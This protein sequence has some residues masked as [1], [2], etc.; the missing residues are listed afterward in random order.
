MPLNKQADAW[1]RFLRQYGPVPQNNNMYDEQIER[2]ARRKNVRPILFDHPFADALLGHFDGSRE[3][4]GAVILTGTAGDGKTFLLKKVWERL[5][6]S[7]NEWAESRSYFRLDATVGGEARRF[8]LVRDLTG[9]SD[10]VDGAAGFDKRALLRRTS[11]AAVGRG[12]IGDVFLLAANDGQLLEECRAL[13]ETEDGTNLYAL[14]ERLL[15][16]PL[17]G[18]APERLVFFNLARGRSTE[19]LDRALDALLGHEGWES[20]RASDVSEDEAFGVRCPIRR[21]LELL[22]NEIVRKRLRALVELCDANDLHLSIREIL[23]VLVNALLGHPAAK[24]QVL[25]PADV[26]LVVAQGAVGRA[27]LYN[28]VFGGNL[29]EHRRETYP[30]FGSLD[31]FRVGYETSN[32][33]DGL[34]VFGPSDPNLSGLYDHLMRSDPIFGE[35]PEFAAAQREYIEGAEETEARGARFLELLVEK[36]RLLFFSLPEPG[37]SDPRLVEQVEEQGLRLWD[38][39]VFKFAGD[40]LDRVVRTL[41]ESGRVEHRILSRIVRGLNRIFVGMF[42]SADRE[43]IL[44]VSPT[45][46]AARVSRLVAERVSVAPSRGQQ[47]RIVRGPNGGAPVLEIAFNRDLSRAF[48][49]TLVRFE[50]LSRVA[51]GMLPSSFSKEC[52]EDVL[53][54]KS[55]LLAALE[56][57][58]DYR[59]RADAPV[60][61]LRVLSLGEDGEPREDLVEVSRD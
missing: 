29:S 9:W 48:D 13:E 37:V 47:V 41:E 28:N 35:D 6:G 21:N 50:F 36:R 26:P 24:D 12:E 25:T 49:L 56:L 43:L 32:Q 17:A 2:W 27:S 54:F 30:V 44:A 14:F 31:R 55:R 38:L 46:S 59:A 42:I 51:D 33:L 1:L 22:G 18:A 10:E 15:L 53:A 34:L 45:S 5:G 23:L 7:L 60:L 57:D 40:Y 19:L 52:Y 4:P 3:L 39:T 16:D 58:D 20:C 11:E 61:A 8:H